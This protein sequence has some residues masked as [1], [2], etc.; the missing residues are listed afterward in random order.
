MAA[1][2]RHQLDVELAVL[3]DRDRLA[4]H[5]AEGLLAVAELAVAVVAAGEQ[6]ARGGHEGRVALAARGGR[7]REAR[8][9]FERLGR[10]GGEA[11]GAEAEL[12]L[13]AVAH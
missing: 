3:V 13:R 7:D 5:A 6:L 8:E 4:L 12:A 9:A 1:A 10:L 11:V 2:A